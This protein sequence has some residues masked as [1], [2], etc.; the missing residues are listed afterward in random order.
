MLKSNQE[1]QQAVELLNNGEVI[2][3]PTE[4]V[5]GLGCDPFSRAAVEHILT[6]KNRE[7]DKGLILVASNIKQV[8]ELLV[9]ITSSQLLKLQQSW[10]GPTTWLIEDPNNFIPQWIKG[11]HSTVAVRVSAHPTVKA[12]CEAF[13]GLLVSTSAN[14]SSLLPA[15]SQHQAQAYFKA[16]VALYVKGSLGSSKEPS[17]IISLEDNVIHR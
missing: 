7:Q 6:I 13:G 1:I 17:K 8:E 15:V 9:N 2:A 11:A 10:P 5:W 3:Y 4:A 12:L 14:P 16:S